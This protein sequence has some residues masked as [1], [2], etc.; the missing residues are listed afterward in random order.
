MTEPAGQTPEF[1]PGSSF[2]GFT[3]EKQIG[4]GG[5][6]RLYLARTDSG[7]QRVLKVP[8]RTFDADPVAVVAFENELR[9][10]HYL[11]DFPNADMPMSQGSGAQHYLVM[12]YIEGT[13]LWTHLREKGCLN[14]AEAIAMA[15]KIVRAM[16]ELHHRRIVHLDIKLSNIMITGA[17][18]VRI[19]DF[20]LANH[21]DLPDLIYESFQDP[22]GTPAYIA[23]EQFYG[24]RDE[25]RSDLYSIGTL[26]YEMTTSKLPFPD[27]HSVLDVINRI[28]RAPI[29]PRKYRPELSEEFAN[30]V[31]TCLQNVPDRRFPSMDALHSAL[32]QIE[33][34]ATAAMTAQ[35]KRTTAPVSVLTGGKLLARLTGRFWRAV[36]MAEGGNLDE[37]KAWIAA[38]QAR[39]AARYRIV[40]ALDNDDSERAAVLNAAILAEAIRQAGLQPSIITV[41]TVLRDHNIALVADDRERK[42]V[43]EAYQKAR[44]AMMRIIA[45]S[46]RGQ[47]SIGVN[48]R[49][50]EA[51]EAI[52]GCVSDYEANLLVIGARERRALSRFALGSTAYKVLTTIK[53]PI[54][55]VQEAAARKPRM[56]AAQAGGGIATDANASL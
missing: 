16:A 29:S 33:P 12:D 49:S 10:A 44:E 36:R 50:G 54:F 46:N 3:V 51:I 13:D 17:G 4:E 6:A 8:R 56:L 27:A 28:K 20:G 35:P 2:D 52:A 41:L 32:E 11:E 15:K 30:L 22:K 39:R 5:M 48:I 47:L 21:L 25:P 31:L 23:P 18:E 19:I 43:N 42:E 14:E 45:D 34:A 24:V 55:V 7:R 38:H 9:L 53:C 40:A 1:E 37:I 26:L